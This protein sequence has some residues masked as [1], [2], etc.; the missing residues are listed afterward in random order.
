[1]FFLCFVFYFERS[2]AIKDFLSVALPAEYIQLL[3]TSKYASAR[4]LNPNSV[5]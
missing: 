4:G 3:I 2:E 5:T 1:M